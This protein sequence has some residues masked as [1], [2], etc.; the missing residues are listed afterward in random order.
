MKVRT[1]ASSRS[2]PT[3]ATTYTLKFRAAPTARS[4]SLT[5]SVKVR[6]DSIG[7]RPLFVWVEF[8]HELE[9]SDEAMDHHLIKEIETLGV[10]WVVIQNDMLS[11]RQEE[12]SQLYDTIGDSSLLTVTTQEEGCCHNLI[13][14]GRLHGLG[15]QEV[16]D[17]CGSR[18]DKIYARFDEAVSELPSFGKAV[19][20]ELRRYVEGIKGIIKAN[21]HWSF[22]TRRYFGLDGEVVKKTGKMD[23]QRT[24]SYLSMAECQE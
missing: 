9:L 11:Y 3:T 17:D 19:D 6:R 8:A 13:S 4:S 24:P 12:V 15:A 20:S 5:S 10:D 22:R 16:F 21:L 18:L 2:S 7:V 14:A 23:I 1:S